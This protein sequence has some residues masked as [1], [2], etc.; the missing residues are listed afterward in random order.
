MLR[1]RANPK[2]TLHNTL[3]QTQDAKRDSAF[4]GKK[5]G[6]KRKKTLYNN[7]SKKPLSKCMKE[8]GKENVL[9]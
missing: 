7:L 1:L 6:K 5:K 3:T 8:K 9:V 2:S 4:N